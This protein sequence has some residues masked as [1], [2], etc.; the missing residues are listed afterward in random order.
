MRKRTT[1]IFAV[2]A[3]F[4]LA[5]ELIGHEYTADATKNEIIYTTLTR[6]VGAFLF[7]FLIWHD[8]IGIFG[9][10]KD[11]KAIL[12]IIPAALVAINNAP[13]IGLATGAAHVTGDA[14]DILLIILQ[15]AAVGLFEEAAFRG[16]FFPLVL[17]RYR[18]RSVFMPTVISSALF[19]AVHLLNLAYGSS[20]AAVILQVGYSFLIGGMCAI[21]LIKTRSIWVVAALHAVYNLGGTLIPTLGEGKVW[22]A[23]TVTATTLL[24]VTVCVIMLVILAKIKNEEAE[25]LYR[26]IK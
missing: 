22:D 17:E 18:G 25:A 3:L 19:A 20:P 7:L 1:L 15:S 16:Y 24:G 12:T 26:N 2:A 14:V 4:L 21:V 13:I 5:V 10:T 11:R 9:I 23:A 8:R 6:T